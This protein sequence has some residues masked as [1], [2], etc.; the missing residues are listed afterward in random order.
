MTALRILVLSTLSALWA[1]S[2]ADGPS[3]DYTFFKERVQP[4]FLKKRP[5]HARCV[6]C[7][8]HSSPPLEPLDRDAVAWNED[9][10]R[11]NF[12][13][14]RQFA[15]PGNPLK[16]PLLLHPL[17][18]AGGGDHFHAGGKHWKSQDDPEWQTLAAWVNG[19]TMGGSK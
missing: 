19:R 9:Q 18:A 16:S 8:S 1:A 4:I 13:I 12:A 15:V 5:G 14:W 10:S 7:H 11:K 3:L 17:A 6:T 2:P